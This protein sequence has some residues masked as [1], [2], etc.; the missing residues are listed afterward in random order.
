MS[1]LND[2]LLRYYQRELSYLRTMG[3][4]FSRR[5]P[6]I[7]HRLEMGVD[8]CVDPLIERLIESFAFLSAR[9]QLN[10]DNE[11][12]EVSTALLNILYP[13]YLCPV[14]SMSVVQFTP[15]PEQGELTGG[16]TIA[17]HTRLYAESGADGV[18]CRFR[19]CY[20]VTLW[21]VEVVGADFESVDQFDFLDSAADVASVLRI[22]LRADGVPLNELSMRQ[23]RFFIHGDLLHVFALYELLFTQVRGVALLPDG[24]T[25]RPRMLSQNSLRPVGFDRDE[26]VLPFQPHAHPGYR[27]LQ[28]YF[29]F[30]DKFL[31]FDV[32]NIDLSKAEESFDILILLK[33]LPTGR[34]TIGADTFRLGCAPIINLFSKITEP[35][36]LD[37]T[38][39]DYR[40]MAD[41]RRNAS[42]EIHTIESVSAFEP[43]GGDSIPYESYFSFT[44]HMEADQQAA[45]WVGRR[46]PATA[47]HLSGTEMSL[48]FVDLDFQP[49]LPPVQ[50]VFART[51]CTNRHMA[52]EIPAGAALEIEEAAPLHA[53]EMLK[54]P[55]LQID[56]P[57]GGSTLWRLI[58]HLSLNHL[59]LSN[60]DASLKALREMLFLY[61]YADSPFVFQQ[62]AGI[63][64]MTTKRVVR[65]MRG[66]AWKGFAR[67]I[68]VSLTF[69]ESLYVGS[70]AY[71]LASVL[72]RF[73]AMYVSIN[74][75]T[76]LKISSVQREGVWKQWPPMA[77]DQIIL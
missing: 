23:L 14:P 49:N 19:T 53:I 1:G 29:T 2:E 12:P 41:V 43:G 75:F 38:Q 72:N 47:A 39:T 40:L 52:E 33:Q 4:A 57:L 76:Q 5:Y 54:K 58:S 9:V 21:P 70:S 15:D 8:E 73:F 24:D 63:K 56:P 22:R 26:A 48:S 50:S 36:R 62:V 20:P 69:D 7:A 10:I 77:G 27:L 55:T 35:I 16:H 34:L 6:K 66:E 51:L 44:H 25:A 74:S 11:L 67:G 18:T 61:N 37:H 3:G 71:L 65:Q 68:E 45:F 60:A 64:E 46:F 32:D 17:R 31:F 42:T 30:P 13:H 59:S 28:E